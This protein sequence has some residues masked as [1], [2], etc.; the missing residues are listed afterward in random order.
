MWS[1]FDNWTWSLGIVFTK[2]WQCLMGKLWLWYTAPAYSYFKIMLGTVLGCTG[3]IFLDLA[4]HPVRM[5]FLFA[6]NFIFSNFLSCFFISKV[7]CFLWYCLMSCVTKP[8][9]TKCFNNFTD[10]TLF[11]LA[12]LKFYFKR[13]GTMTYAIKQHKIWFLFDSLLMYN[14]L[15]ITCS[16]PMDDFSLTFKVFF[17]ITIC[18][19]FC[20]KNKSFV[21]R[22][23]KFCT[24]RSYWIKP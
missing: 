22:V 15:R 19:V 2:I 14:V 5:W 17:H 20:H 23:Q 7:F 11:F 6:W 18:L 3:K 12:C 4:G 16:I 9:N 8:A 24:K 13:G 21:V 10:F 1:T